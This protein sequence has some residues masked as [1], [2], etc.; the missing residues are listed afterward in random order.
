MFRLR[1]LRKLGAGHH[2]VHDLLHDASPNI[3]IKTS[4]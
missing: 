4:M 2:A 1:Q 3:V